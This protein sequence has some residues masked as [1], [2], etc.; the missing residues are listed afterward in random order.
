MN[1]L[2]VNMTTKTVKFEKSHERY[3][4]YGLRGLIAKIAF[5]EI[6]PKCDALGPNNKLIFSTSPLQGFGLSSTGRL[7]VGGKSPLTGGI[8]EASSGGVAATMLVRHGI[9]AIILEGLDKDEGLYVLHINQHGAKLLPG[10]HLL[11]KGT[12]ETAKTIYQEFGEKVGLITIGQAGEYKL[13]AAGVFVND[14]DGDPSRPCARGGLGA[15]MGSKGLKAIVIESDGKHKHSIADEEAFKKA[16][17][18]FNQ[19]ILDEP[20]IKTYTEFGTLGM[21][22]TLNS[23][24]GMPTYNFRKGKWEKAEEI[25]GDKFNELIKERGGEGKITHKCMP[26]CLIQCSNV[27]P[28]KN[29]R[30]IVAPMEYETVALLGSN[31]GIADLD[32]CALFN[33]LCNDYGLDTIEVGGALGVAADAGIFDFG[34]AKK[35]EKLINEIGSGTHL[36]RILGSGSTVTGKVFG[37]Y[38]VPAVKG[39][40][41]AGHEPRGIK[42]MGVTYAMG[43]MG[44]DHTAGATYRA[45]TDHHKPEGAMEISRNVQVIT[46]YYDNFFCLFVSRGVGKQPNLITDVINAIYNTELDPDFLTGLGKEIIKLEHIFNKAAG[47]C[48]HYLP[49]YMKYEKLEPEML[50]SDIP[51]ED[52]NRFWEEEFWGKFPVIS[53]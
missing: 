15:V 37:I 24:S 20:A 48:N 29:G 51:N 40:N 25:S 26:G 42:S 9:K 36:G 50:T 17:K 16:R 2:R 32:K 52:Y 21:L 39:Q 19:A 14:L 44:A 31:L 38:R 8:K 18:A 45:P 4:L 53:Q 28:D 11:K 33:K 34:D 5:E 49:E 22:M 41:M 46:T 6:D 7:S 27:F 23:L 12:Y 13:G 47:I 43:A 10:G 30:K 1:L 35:I 3:Q